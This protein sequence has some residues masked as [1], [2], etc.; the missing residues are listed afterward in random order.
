MVTWREFV[1]FSGPLTPFPE[2]RLHHADFPT[3]S[4]GWNAHFDAMSGSPQYSY[5][6][7]G[8]LDLDGCHF[9]GGQFF[10]D[11]GGPVAR[12]LNVRNTV[13][14]RCGVGIYDTGFYAEQF[15]DTGHS[16][17]VN[18][19]NNLF[20]QCPILLF[21]VPGDSAGN[22]WTFSD[23]IFDNVL[24]YADAYGLYNGPVGAN[25]HNA[26]VG[27][28]GLGNGANRLTPPAPAITDPD[29]A[30]LA[31]ETG[32]LGNFY[33]PAVATNLIGKGA[34]L[35]GAAGEY[36]FTCLTSQT[37]AG[38]GQVSIGPHYLAL[39]SGGVPDSNGDGIPDFLADRN[40]SGSQDSDE[41]PWQAA[42]TGGLARPED[43]GPA[44]AT[45]ES[46]LGT[47]AKPD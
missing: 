33:L 24:F 13:F 11:D 43:A 34:R 32:P 37:K 25:N 22:N 39:A 1:F 36:H 14:D 17:Q 12:G 28:A 15:Y 44:S 9:Q 21:P 46:A 3:V 41:P 16:A 29:L 18:I 6:V 47:A 42:S 8:N 26:Y 7:I 27:M 31:Y 19:A 4:G 20:Y 2:A 45:G 40:G 38:A 10:Y 23:N 5:S 35:A 30:S